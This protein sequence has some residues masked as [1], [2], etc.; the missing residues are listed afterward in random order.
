[1]VIRIDEKTF[2]NEVEFNRIIKDI[3]SNETVQ[4]MKNYPQHCNTNCFDHCYRV[5]FYCYKICKK[6]GL[7][8]VS[9]AR[10]GMLHDLFLYDWRK[11]ENGRKGLHAFTHGKTACENAC[12]E[13]DLTEKEKDMII[14]HMWPVTPVL[15]KSK[16]G[17]VLTLADKLSALS[18][19]AEFMS[20]KKFVRYAYLAMCIVFIGKI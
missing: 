9:A 3:V 10:A 8:Y 18:E 2:E 1:M 13:F 16:E 20:S 4:K 14:K 5:S 19:F 15:P 7:D 17:F 11:R 6:L 12:K